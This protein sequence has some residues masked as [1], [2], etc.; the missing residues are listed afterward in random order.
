MFSG[1]QSGAPGPGHGQLTTPAGV[2]ISSNIRVHRRA[3]RRPDQ[4]VWCGR[5]AR[6]VLRLLGSWAGRRPCGASRV[7]ANMVTLSS[8]TAG[9]NRITEFDL[10]GDFVR[11]WG[12]GVTDGT[13]AL[14]TCTA[15]CLDGIGGVRP[16]N[17]RIREPRRP[18]RHRRGEN[19]HIFVAD[20]GN[21]RIAEY[22]ADRTFIRAWG[23]DVIPGGGT[24]FENCTTATGCKAGIE[25]PLDVCGLGQFDKPSDIDVDASGRVLV[26]DYEGR[27]VTRF[28]DDTPPPDP[29][30]T[31]PTPTDPTPTDPDA[32]R[33][34]PTR[35]QG[36]VTDDH[37]AAEGE[38]EDEE[39]EDAVLRRVQRR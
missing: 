15:A 38:S 9:R 29:T 12:F 27:Y 31:D 36:T 3:D 26:V 6:R 5:T 24:G 1:C 32:D 33:P 8:S 11:T 20:D 14:Q 23:F 35:H 16:A 21:N 10:S 18:D 30:P 19:G 2:A 37:L 28:V 22:A 4:S 13:N 34:D 7:A 25:C 17:C 39:E